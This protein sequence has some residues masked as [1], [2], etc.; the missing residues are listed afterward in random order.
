MTVRSVPLVVAVTA[1]EQAIVDR[2]SGHLGD[3]LSRASGELWTCTCTFTAEPKELAGVTAGAVVVTSL[4]LPL[5]NLD[6]PWSAVEQELHATYKALCE[7]GDTVMICTILR[8]VD[9]TEE[10]GRA[11]RIRRR[12][13]KLNL[14]AT[15][16]SRQYGAFVIDLDR[17]LADVGGRHLKTDFRLGGTVAAEFAS[18]TVALYIATNALDPFVAVKIQDK[19]C[20]ILEGERAAVRLATEQMMTDVM[21][22]GQGRRRQRVATVTDAVEENHVSWLVRQVLKGRVGGREAFGKLAG[23]IRRRGARESAALLITGVSRMLRTPDAGR[24]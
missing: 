1:N 20:A 3:A 14:L 15:E 7:S 2:A 21:A 13:R 12:I 17:V 11:A 10:A 24:R 6:R 19:A 18:K 23:A 8:H 9:A 4:L 16:L 5:A 22:L